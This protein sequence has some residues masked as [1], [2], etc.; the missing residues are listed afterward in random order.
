[1]T[2]LHRAGYAIRF[3]I[4]DEVILEAPE[5]SAMG[6]GEAIRLMCALPGW[7]EGLPLDAAG[8]EGHYY[9]KD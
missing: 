5:G 8:F 6:L 3:H 1:M 2:N 9:R 4:H 7:A